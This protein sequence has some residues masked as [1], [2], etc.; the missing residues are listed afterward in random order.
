VPPVIGTHVGHH[1]E[2]FQCHRCLKTVVGIQNSK[3]RRIWNVAVGDLGVVSNGRG[4]VVSVLLGGDRATRPA[5]MESAT[6]SWRMPIDCNG[7]GSGTTIT[8]S[9]STA[10]ASR[11]ARNSRHWGRQS[12]GERPKVQVALGTAFQ[13]PVSPWGRHS[14][15]ASSWTELHNGGGNFVRWISEAYEM[16]VGAAD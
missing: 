14:L 3:E 6:A 9:S 7:V 10:Q 12:T 5:V 4:D 16:R 2:N 8:D 15:F 11:L 13:E 1:Q